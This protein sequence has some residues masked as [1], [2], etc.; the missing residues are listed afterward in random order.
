MAEKKEKIICDPRELAIQFLGDYIWTKDENEP[1]AETSFYT[2]RRW[3]EDCFIWQDGKYNRR[4]DDTLRVNVTAYLQKWAEHILYTEKRRLKVSRALVNDVIANIQPLIHIGESIQLNSFLDGIDRG[5]FLSLKNGLLNLETR[6]LINHTP[7]YFTTVCLP[8]DYD[9]DAACPEFELFLTDIMLGRQDY[10]ELLQE[11]I[12]YLFRPDLREQKFLLCVG[13]GANGKGVL[14]EVIQSLVGIENCSQVPISRFADRFSLNSTIGRIANLTHESSHILENEAE[15]IL[16][17]Y[18]AGDSLTID[19]KHRD[20]IDIQPTAKLLIATNSLPRFGDKTQAIWRR[21]LL[22]PFDLVLEEQ[23]QIKNKAEYLKK[24]L[25]GILNWALAGL[26]RL[27]ANGFTIPQGQKELMEE[28]RRDADPARAFLMDNYSESLNGEY[29]PCGELY[30]AYKEF[31]TDNGC[32]PM[33]ERT[34]GQHV[35]RIFPKVKRRRMGT[36]KREYVYWGLTSYENRDYLGRETENEETENSYC[37][38]EN[39]TQSFL[40]EK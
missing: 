27:N 19:R 2:L 18:V 22:V 40:D 38:Q 31:C 9:P 14:F 21:I 16:K 12:G 17:S 7:N 15:N 3:K 26:G 30:K 37:G 32:H 6:E 25:P 10:I 23:Y 1:K 8:Y 4:A 34:F 36:A 35:K 39:E 33:N 11:F 5:R 28:Y 29:V 13:A 24:E 20:P